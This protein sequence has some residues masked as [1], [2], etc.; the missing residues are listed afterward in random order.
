MNLIINLYLLRQN[1][2][3]TFFECSLFWFVSSLFW[4]VF[5]LRPS[6]KCKS[7]N[8]S[9]SLDIVMH[10][11]R[12]FSWHSGR[13]KSTVVCNS[14]ELFLCELIYGISSQ[15]QS[16]HLHLFQKKMGLH[17]DMDLHHK[18]STDLC[19]PVDGSFQELDFEFFLVSPFQFRIFYDTPLYLCSFPFNSMV[20]HLLHLPF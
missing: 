13:L 8:Y 10:V 14:L 17:H 19:L 7:L 11:S 12:N 1:R 6:Q 9:P 15:S 16:K 18:S 4:F 5:F 2:V 20:T 3:I